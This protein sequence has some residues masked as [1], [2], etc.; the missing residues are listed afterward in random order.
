MNG[1]L[2]VAKRAAIEGGELVLKLRSKKLNVKVKSNISDITTQADKKSEEI[3]LEIIKKNFPKHGILTEESGVIEEGSEYKWVI[4]PLDG[5]LAY[6]SGLPIF[7]VSIGLLRKSKP[8]LGVINLP[9]L[10]SLYWAVR[11]KGSY[12]N[13]KRIKVSNTKEF[14]K[15]AVGFDFGYA[16]GRIYQTLKIIKNFP[17]K[18]RYSPVFA[19]VSASLC[20]VSQGGLDAYFHTAKI[21]DFAA[22]VAIIEEAGGKVTDYRGDAIDWTKEE[23]QVVASNGKV[24]DDILSL[25]NR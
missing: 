15:G 23:L 17:G 10:G 8:Y 9:F 2:E 7:G 19:C 22:G 20:F 14:K 12:I 24:H 5:T 1:M 21:W 4:D 6:S 13:D 3:I 18:I 25:I 11:G 16:S